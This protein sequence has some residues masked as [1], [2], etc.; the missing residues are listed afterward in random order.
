MEESQSCMN[1]ESKTFSAV[2]SL[3]ETARVPGWMEARAQPVDARGLQLRA[4]ALE[5]AATNRLSV[6][7]TLASL[8]QTAS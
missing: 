3:L 2:H 6:A 4:A 1:W 8:R 5:R 7:R